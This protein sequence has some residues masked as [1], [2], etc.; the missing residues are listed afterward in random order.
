MAAY[1][2]LQKADKAPYGEDALI[3]DLALDYLSIGAASPGRPT[4]SAC[5]DVRDV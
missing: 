3:A 1:G 2:A 4:M 5:A